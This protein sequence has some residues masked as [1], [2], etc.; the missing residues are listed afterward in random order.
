[1]KFNLLPLTLVIAFLTTGVAHAENS[2]ACPYLQGRYACPATPTQAAL[3][4]ELVQTWKGSEAHYAFH[5]EG[6][7][8][9]LAIASPSGV[10]NA[11]PGGDTY[12]FCVDRSLIYV[13]KNNEKGSLQQSF[14]GAHGEYVVKVR[15]KE[16]IRCARE[17]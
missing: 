16:V 6:F 15:G 12:I 14:L 1:M 11:F 2:S 4:F 7:P 9:D 17:P 13:P 10:L 8:D 5:Y 3:R